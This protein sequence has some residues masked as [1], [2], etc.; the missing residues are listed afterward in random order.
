[1]SPSLREASRSSI[2]EVVEIFSERGEV[3]IA[4]GVSNASDAPLYMG[5]GGN[6]DTALGT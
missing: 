3:S 5:A 1:M 4:G 2:G 6:G